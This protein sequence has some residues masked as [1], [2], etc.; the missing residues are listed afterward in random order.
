[1]NTAI[2]LLPAR[3]RLSAQPLVEPVAR[4]LGRS[5]RTVPADAGE[6]AQLLRHFELLPRGF[7][8]A[9]LTRQ[10]DAGDA[11]H[12]A[13]LRADP[14]YVRPDISGAQLLACGESLQLTQADADALLPALR[15]LFGDCGFLLD[16]P[17]P[18]RWYLRLPREAK[19]PVFAAPADALGANLLEQLPGMDGSDSPES[20]R[21]RSLLS[22]SQIVLHN[23]PHNAARLAAGKVPVNSL[24]LWGGGLLPD[25]V[26]SRVQFVHTDDALLRALALAANLCVEAP[27]SSFT[28]TDD[29]GLFDLRALRDPDSLCK[30]WL[31]PAMA[32]LQ[33]R[34]IGRLLLDC[35][36]GNG[37]VLERHQ[38]WRFWRKLLLTL[39]A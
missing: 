38:R 13:W 15:P 22:E 16:A 28:A 4:A 17:A 30:H 36:D 7:P 9:A 35:E 3:R 26:T 31:Q 11:G 23:H 33:T 18:G 27:A 21:W 32:A 2:L 12:G 39:D 5:D 1:M 14:A 19:L 6:R 25:H 34:R 29:N 37:F 20:R 10:A 24:W 8:V